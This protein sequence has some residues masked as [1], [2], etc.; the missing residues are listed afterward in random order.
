M[1]VASW[2]NRPSR[3]PLV[4]RFSVLN[5]HHEAFLKVERFFRM[6]LKLFNASSEC[7]PTNLFY[8]IYKTTAGKSQ[9]VTMVCKYITLT[10][11]STTAV[12]MS[13]SCRRGVRGRCLA[14]RGRRCKGLRT[15]RSCPLPCCVGTH[16]VRVPVCSFNSMWSKKTKSNQPS[17]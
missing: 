5:L 10:V 14:A 17:Y 9:T 4:L 7:F 15:S 12:T 16:T 1:T 3:A 11:A 6:K 8:S 13:Y 2:E